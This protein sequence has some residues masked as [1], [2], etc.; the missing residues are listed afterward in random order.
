VLGE[1]FRSPDAS[2]MKQCNMQGSLSVQA[3]KSAEVA[4]SCN[5]PLMTVG[6]VLW[7]LLLW[8]D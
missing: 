3:M 7:K 2:V 4:V 5:L 6:L 8:K 1:E